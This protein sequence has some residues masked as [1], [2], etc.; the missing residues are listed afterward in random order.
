M[1]PSP[2]HSLIRPA[3]AASESST[4]LRDSHSFPI[5]LYNK[6]VSLI[7]CLLNFCRPTAVLLTVSFIIV[8]PIQAH[9]SF[10]EPHVLNE[11]IKRHPSFANQD[12]PPA[13]IPKCG[14]ISISAPLNHGRPQLIHLTATKAVTF[15]EVRYLTVPYTPTGSS[16]PHKVCNDHSLLFSTI[17]STNP[18]STRWER[19]LNNN[20]STKP[21]SNSVSKCRHE[22]IKNIN[23]PNSQHI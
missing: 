4:P 6:I 9:S 5:N 19:S 15:I 21:L 2:T 17:A 13:V 22:D 16:V 18:S 11:S 23:T 3:L 20:Q 14:V 12:T 7:V 10:R 8:D 1:T